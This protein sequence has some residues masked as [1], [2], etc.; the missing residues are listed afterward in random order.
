M[1][2][3][4]L[5]TEMQRKIMPRSRV[6]RAIFL[7]SVIDKWRK[8]QRGRYDLDR[9]IGGVCGE[10]VF[11]HALAVESCWPFYAKEHIHTQSHASLPPDFIS[12]TA[13]RALG[14]TGCPFCL[15]MA[16]GEERRGES[17]R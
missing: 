6:E 3:R 8:R 14:V 1:T 4:D 11:H 10:C 7:W 9:G 15:L 17:R 16:S 2:G 13:C 5:M 12:Q